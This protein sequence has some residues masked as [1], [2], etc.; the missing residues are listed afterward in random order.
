MFELTKKEYKNLRS[1]VG[2]SR[3]VGTRYMLACDVFDK[4]ITWY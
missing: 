1:Q 2:P 3:G 4:K